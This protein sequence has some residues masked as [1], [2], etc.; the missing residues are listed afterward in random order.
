MPDPVAAPRNRFGADF[1]KVFSAQ[2][3]SSLGSSF[4]LFALPLLVYQL[5]GS[6]IN[7]ALVTAAEYLPYLLFGLFAG[8]AVDRMNRKWLM[9]AADGIQALVIASIPLLALLDALSVWW[10]Y[11]VG[12][13]SSSLWLVF[14]TAE[15]AALPSLVRKDDL[16]AANGRMQAGYAAASVTGP[17][18][19]GFFASFAPIPTILLFDALSFAVSAALVAA[20]RTPFSANEQAGARNFRHE[21][22]E[23]LRYVWRHPLLRNVAAMMALVNCVGYTVYAQLVL[24]AKDRLDASD[25]RVGLLYAVGSAGMIALA[26]AAGPVRRHLPFGLATLGTIAL[27]GGLIVLFSLT[28]SY[29]LAA[30][31][32]ALIWGLVVLFQ[33][34]ANSLWQEI[35]PNR[36]LGRVQGIVSAISLSAIPLGTLAGGLAIEE[37]GSV[38]LV[39]GIVGAAI[40]A[41]A[42]AFS[43]TSLRRAEHYLEQEKPR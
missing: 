42:L 16:A 32:W 24:F 11:A 7:L 12:F 15:F 31:L 17:A 21:V 14:N 38:A 6:A 29:W 5:T 30:A 10:I 18:L 39:Y 27:G 23:G 4:T 20:I 13:I 1:Y 19:A 36:L 25:F 40:L 34:N 3:I 8:A 37:T 26:L 43:L 33:V 28:T 41:S 22:A 9:V 2:T 35:V